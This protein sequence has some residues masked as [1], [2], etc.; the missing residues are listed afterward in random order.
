MVLNTF[1]VSAHF[2]FSDQIC[3]L[4]K[5]F[6]LSHNVREAG[7]PAAG[8]LAGLIKPR[9]LEQVQVSVPT[10]ST[11][12]LHSANQKALQLHQHVPLAQ[13]TTKSHLSSQ[14]FLRKLELLLYR[15]WKINHGCLCVHRNKQNPK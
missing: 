4:P 9:Q 10:G 11:L 13:P 12:S 1:D 7:W 15:V 2:S 3:N 14:L 6:N 8:G 5:S